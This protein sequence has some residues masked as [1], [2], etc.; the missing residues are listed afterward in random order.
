MKPTQESSPSA[1]PELSQGCALVTG[2]GSGIGRET[3]LTL[4]LRGARVLVMGRR[5]EPLD[6]VVA[7]IEEAGGSAVRFVG[8][9]TSP[10]DAA[11]AVA[12]AIE[13]FGGLDILVNNAGVARGGPIDSM[14]DQDVQLVVDV[15][16]VGTIH[17]IRAA[18]P[19]LGESNFAPGASIVNVSTSVTMA[20][21]KNF[22]VYAASKSGVDVLT[23]SLALELADR[24][25]R[26]NAIC[27]GIVE[28]PI[29]ETMMP[30]DQVGGFLGHFNQAVPL[31]RVGSPV[32]MARLVAF[33]VSEQASYITGAIIPIDGG[34]SLSADGKA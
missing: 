14:S 8:D 28:T 25:I 30:R 16:L 34:L 6:R 23:K 18:L 33:L 31:G 29:F 21:I 4:A 5:Q 13:S 26:V 32:D 22:S 11:S 2:G 20:P 19:A 15:N 7:E 3:A 10:A 1:A 17:M 12:L 9:V 27:P 24:G